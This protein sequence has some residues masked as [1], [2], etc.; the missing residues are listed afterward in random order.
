MFL[1]ADL[2]QGR[3]LPTPLL[4]DE[5]A[6]TVDDCMLHAAH[7]GCMW[8]I[9]IVSQGNHNISVKFTAVHISIWLLHGILQHIALADSSQNLGSHS[10]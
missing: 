2:K 4:H 8:R 3:D 5:I 1:P 7:L 10:Y 9:L 6:Y